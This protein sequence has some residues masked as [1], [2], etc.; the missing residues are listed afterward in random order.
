MPVARGFGGGRLEQLQRVGNQFWELGR[1][2]LT[3]EGPP[4]RRN[5]AARSQCQPTGEEA[6]G[7]RVEVGRHRGTRAMVL[8]ATVGLGRMEVGGPR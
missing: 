1:K 6:E 3:G 8:E 5:R 2:W 7:T 4:R